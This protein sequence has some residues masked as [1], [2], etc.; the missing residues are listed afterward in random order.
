MADGRGSRMANLQQHDIEIL[1]SKIC[2][3][4]EKLSGQEKTLREKQKKLDILANEKDVWKAIAEQREKELSNIRSN[5]IYQ[6]LASIYR[7]MKKMKSLGKSSTKNMVNNLPVFED[8]ENP[9]VSV[10]IPVYNNADYLEQC[11]ESV[12]NQTYENIEIIVV[13]DCSTDNRVKEILNK[14]TKETKF[15]VYYNDVN[16][17][18]SETTNNAMCQAAGDW[19][20]FLDCDDWL[21]EQAIEKMLN[22][23]HRKKGA[24]FGYSNRYN[25]NNLTGEKEEVDFKIRP[26]V[27]YEKNL[28][29]GM[30]TSHLKM[31]H[32]VAFTKI[33]LFDSNFN[34]TQDYD[35]SL[36]IAHY[37]GDAAFAFLPEPIYYHRVHEKQT[38]M[39]QNDNM[40][41]GTWQLRKNSEMRRQIRSGQYHKKVSI[42]ILSFNKG[43][44]TVECIESIRKTVKIPYEIIVWD[45]KSNEKTVKLLKEKIEPLAEVRMFYSETNLGAGG[46][47]QKAKTYATGDY[48]VFLDNDIVVLDDWLT[49]LIVRMES[50][51]SVAAVNCKV[52]FPNQT[53]QINSLHTV[54]EEPFITF[55]LGG[56]NRMANDLTTCQWKENDW[57]NGGATIYRKDVLLSLEGLEEYPNSFEDNEAGIQMREKGYKLLNSP[58]SVVIHNHMNYVSLKRSDKEYVEAR[59]DKDN[60]IISAAVFYKRH[61]LI[62]NDPFIFGLMGLE[63]Q[64][65]DVIKQRFDEILLNIKFE[66]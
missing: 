57:I 45:N 2:E 54:V 43:E 41:R 34:G 33:G 11:F 18:I 25:Y 59:Y 46:G 63:N 28:C 48:I 44:Q 56:V 52:I 5:K 29:L 23:L 21:E 36:K 49:E 15:R 30:Y 50:E 8:K 60:L 47:R 37:F 26:T 7:W 62:I 61:G 20:A 1:K 16:S 9:L 17:G 66:K 38:T 19:F 3:L 40:M 31:I 22:C 14:Y 27:E 39:V 55:A 4:E 53:V 65:R 51:E 24:V 6:K 35:I 32:R 10:I 42:V 64:S 12:R 13:D 58:C